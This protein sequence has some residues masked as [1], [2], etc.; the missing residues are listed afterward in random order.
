MNAFRTLISLFIRQL[1]HRRSVVIIV[2]LMLLMVVINFKVINRF[3]D[4]LED[5]SSYDVA[6]RRASNSLNRYANEITMFGV[7]TIVLVSALIAPG[8]RRD[9]TTQFMF[10]IA[11]GRFRFAVSQFAALAAFVLAA[12]ML[13]HVGYVIPAMMLDAMTL[14]EILLSWIFLFV[15]MLM[16]SLVIYMISLSH[17]ALTSYALILGV[18]LIILPAYE[19]LL[20]DLAKDDRAV[21]F[22]LQRM[23]N[24]LMFFYPKVDTFMVWPELLPKG[25]PGV[26]PVPV[27]T[28]S[29]LHSCSAILF[30]VIVGSWLFRH[31]SIG[32]RNLLK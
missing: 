1:L 24:N 15:P 30:W 3:N 5:G 29:V 8:S 10:T 22:F 28:W 20:G 11:V 4:F 21:A 12:A 23:I 31:A 16:L 26:L 32:S 17:A 18:P 13:V 6:T 9:G 7:I 25:D 2:I 19:G 27:W 14:P